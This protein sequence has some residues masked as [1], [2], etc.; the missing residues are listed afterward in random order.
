MGVSR[1]LKVVGVGLLAE[2]V[3][4]LAMVLAM[5]IGRT[6]LGISPPPE[7][8]PDRFAP[9]LDINTFFSLFGR[10]GGYNGLKRFGITSGLTGLFVLGAVVGVAYA[11]VVESVRSRRT[12]GWRTGVSPFGLAFV[13][14]A[15][16]V[17]WLA[18]VAVLWPVLDANY[19]GLPPSQ[20]RVV[21]AL[22]LLVDYAI[23]GA[24]LILAYRFVIR[25]DNDGAARSDGGRARPRIQGGF[26]GDHS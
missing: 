20:A 15:A 13:V 4:S 18:T 1:W 24:V 2:V 6:W 10:F 21:S 11:A 23:Y 14:V 12:S 16:V 22:G 17:L 5:A 19:R 7:A 26:G 9:T 3:A 25:R 8:I